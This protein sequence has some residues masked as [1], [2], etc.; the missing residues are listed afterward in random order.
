MVF[1]PSSYIRVRAPPPLGVHARGRFGE[2]CMYVSMY[3]SVDGDFL[4]VRGS[5]SRRLLFFSFFFFFFSLPPS[6]FSLPC[7]LKSFLFSLSYLACTSALDVCMDVLSVP[8]PHVRM[9]VDTFAVHV[10]T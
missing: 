9:C 1:R 7:G 2:T 5:F 4:W 8:S 6:L 3:L 10:V